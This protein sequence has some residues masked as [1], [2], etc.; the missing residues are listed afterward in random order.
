MYLGIGQTP[1]FSNTCLHVANSVHAQHQT[2]SLSALR[3]KPQ[4]KW[5]KI[6]KTSVFVT[7]FWVFGKPKNEQNAPHGEVIF[8]I[9]N[10]QSRIYMYLFTYC[11]V[12]TGFCG[13]MGSET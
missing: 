9:K 4:P 12:F 1:K 6:L 5:I 13:E 10:W 11:H 8:P 7:Y 2:P 3:I